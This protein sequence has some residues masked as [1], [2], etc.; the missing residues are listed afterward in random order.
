MPDTLRDGTGTGSLAKVDS[1]NRLYT[2]ATTEGM[3]GHVNHEEGK[4]YTLIVAKTPTG[5]GDCFC[6]IKNTSDEDLCIN[7]LKLY[8]ATSETIQIKVNDKGTA[9]GGTAIVPVNRNT[10][11]S[12]RKSVV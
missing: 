8:A 5:A 1:E 3:I 6:Y 9:A 11:F 7:S 10:N 2:R 12:T 4:S